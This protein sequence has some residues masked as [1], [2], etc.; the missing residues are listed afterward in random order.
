MQNHIANLIKQNTL[1]K[2]LTNKNWYY[3]VHVHS[4]SYTADNIGR[5]T[6]KNLQLVDI[7]SFSQDKQSANIPH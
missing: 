3:T 5:I 4:M 6:F 1:K 2:F 7:D